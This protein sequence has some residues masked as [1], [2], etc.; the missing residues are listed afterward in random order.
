MKNLKQDNVM[1]IN[2]WQFDEEVADVFDNMLERSIP[3]YDVMRSTCFDLAVQF[4]LKGKD[5]VDIG[6]A[7]GEAIASLVD[8]FGAQNRF[9]GLEISESMIK[10]TRKRFEGYIDTNVVDIR[11]HDLRQKLPNFSACVVMSVLTIQFTPIE[12]RQRII[13][14]VCDNL[15]E[16]GAFIFVEKVLGANSYIDNVFVK[17]YLSL[18][19]KNG[20]SQD[21]IERK[22]LSLEGVLVPVT[23][24]WNEE[25]LK[26]SGFK[27]IDCFWRWMNFAGWIAIK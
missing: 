14:D 5:I 12:H 27:S 8:R 24:K 2:K 11:K 17:N 20:Y 18:K 16:K 3:Q 22:K 25:L 10:A 23:A 26:M 13:Q 1:P 15:I 7:G 21:Q 6:C 4:Q 9:I 19:S